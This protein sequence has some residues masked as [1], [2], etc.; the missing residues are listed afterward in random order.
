MKMTRTI[1]ILLPLAVLLAGSAAPA[2]TGVVESAAVT[3]EVPPVDIMTLRDPFWPVGWR[4]PNF[5]REDV[6]DT[7]TAALQ[8]EA[9]GRRLAVTGLSKK[10]DGGY[11]AILKGAGLVETGDTIAVKYQGLTYKWKV[12]KITNTGIIRER[13]S[14]SR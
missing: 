6:E 11:L 9:A 2:Q 8:W 1:L 7:G 4:P 13:L 14:V 5:G 12:T 10:A 3:N